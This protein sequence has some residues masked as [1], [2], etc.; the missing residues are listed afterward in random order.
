[1]YVYPTPS[2]R[3]GSD[4][5][6]LFTYSAAGLKSKEKRWIHAFPKGMRVK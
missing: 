1:M 4:T 6:S 2:L 5:R 3:A